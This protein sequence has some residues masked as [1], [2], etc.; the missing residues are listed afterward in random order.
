MNLNFKL[1]LITDR[2]LCQ[3]RSLEE[4]IQQALEAGVKAVQLREKDL[5]TQEL[6]NLADTLKD[7]ISQYK[8][9]QLLINDRLD[10][11]LALK[12][13]G[14]QVPEEGAPLSRIREFT[15]GKLMGASVHSLEKALLAEQEG[16][17]FLL[18]GPVFETDSK[19]GII[20]PQG[21]NKLKETAAHVKIPVFAVGGITPEKAKECLN[22][23][24]E[25]VA[26][27]SSILKSK[28][29]QKTVSEFKAALGTL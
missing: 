25:G 4:T 1:Y 3:E 20:N 28:E 6:F 13:D 8:G 11:F 21:L 10:L 22:H 14:I 17:D 26:V 16:A 2:K 27:I 23:G 19:K 15:R 7:L 24:A 12:L 29:I 18:F 5:T 9:G